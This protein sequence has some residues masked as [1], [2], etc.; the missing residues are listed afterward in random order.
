MNKPNLILLHGAIGSEA[1]FLKVK[2]HLEDHF[3]LHAFNFSGHGGETANQPYSIQ[4]FSDNLL[5]YLKQHKIEKADIF[6]YS[7]GGYVALY[8]ASI[9]PNSIGTIM[10]LATKFEW[11]EA[12]AQKEIKMLNADVIEEKLPA[13][14]AM[15]ALRH[16]PEDWKVVLKRTAAFM[17]DLGKHPVLT[18]KVLNN[19]NHK[20]TIC[21]GD[22][23]TMV[24][25]AESKF[26]SERLPNAKLSILE[27][28]KHP[29]EQIDPEYLSELIY[30]TFI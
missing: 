6:G 7:M 21:I 30:N 25:I 12:I 27:G 2:K 10:T 1:Q 14:A 28:I 3:T 4:L 20:S 17:L 26:A 24:S 5:S 19:I 13:F 22:A 11:S 29:I 9:A 23:D 18:E 8:T 15:L 16:E